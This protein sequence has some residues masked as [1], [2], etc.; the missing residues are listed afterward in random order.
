MDSIQIEEEYDLTV[1]LNP[2]TAHAVYDSTKDT[3][4]RFNS[5][6][7]THD[8]YHLQIESG[9]ITL[10]KYLHPSNRYYLIQSSTYTA[11]E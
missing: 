2:E 1:V 8:A 10:R 5:W 6:S 11:R 7:E 3:V 4:H 9:T